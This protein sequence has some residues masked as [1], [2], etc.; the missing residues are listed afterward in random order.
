MAV[1]RDWAA[2][3]T[4]DNTAAVTRR[5]VGIRLEFDVLAVRIFLDG[6]GPAA[7]LSVTFSVADL[8]HL[9][10]LDG[11]LVGGAQKLYLDKYQ[12]H[13]VVTPRTRPGTVRVECLAGLDHQ[14]TNKNRPRGV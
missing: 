9:I 7:V 11:R 10:Q 12:I 5:T 3:I 14:E 13:V 8:Q 6:E 2:N 4:W 1:P